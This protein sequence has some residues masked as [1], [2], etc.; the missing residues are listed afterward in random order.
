[1]CGLRLQ[2]ICNSGNTFYR[3][4]FVPGSTFEAA[5]Q[6][7]DMGCTLGFHSQKMP[8]CHDNA[9]PTERKRN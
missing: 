4:L 6:R 8:V 1:M 5:P 7:G 9:Q 3:R 2:W